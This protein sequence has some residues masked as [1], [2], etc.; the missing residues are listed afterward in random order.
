MQYKLHAEQ[1]V[2]ALGILV[3]KH[4]IVKLTGSK[5][6]EVLQS[7]A[8]ACHPDLTTDEIMCF[9]SHSFC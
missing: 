6:S 7:V 8:K 3:S 2:R 4:V 1:N 5:I 9:S